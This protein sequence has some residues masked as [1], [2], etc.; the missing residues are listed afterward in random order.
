MPQVHDSGRQS[1]AVR[2]GDSLLCRSRSSPLLT[3]SAS[4]AVLDGQHAADQA[5]VPGNERQAPDEVD[6]DLVTLR[7]LLVPEHVD[8]QAGAQAMGQNLVPP[9]CCHGP[10]PQFSFP[11][12][13][14]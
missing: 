14:K 6:W 9:T 3:A 2:A 8:S 12:A 5:L 7:V 1:E 11:C 4:P 13:P 10:R